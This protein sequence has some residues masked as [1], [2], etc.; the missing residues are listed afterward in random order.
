M[1]E[2]DETRLLAKMARMYYQQ[3]M[4]QAQIAARV[5]M[6]RQKVQR[7]L[8]KSRETG[9]VHILIKPAMG[10]FADMERALEDRYR[11]R[12]VVVTETEAYD[13]QA[14]VMQEVAAAAA[15]YVCRVLRSRDRIVVAWGGNVQRTIDALYH[16]P[17]PNVKGVSVVQGFGGLGDTNDAEHVTFLTQRL[18]GWLGVPGRIM[19]APVLAGSAQA[20]KAFCSDPSIS[21]VLDSARKANLLITGIGVPSSAVRLLKVNRV[22]HPELAGMPSSGVAGDINLRF[23][24]AHGRPVPSDFDERLIGLTLKEMA[25]FDMAVGVA[26]GAL[27][28]KPLLGAVRGRLIN[29]LVTDNVTARRLLDAPDA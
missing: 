5:S 1:V 26:G 13:D 29:V 22:M 9:V 25:A 2:I 8:K 18:A 3:D 27:K 24:D 6:S 11:L 12:D 19:P 20:R 16:H 15:E 17:R 28:F 7:L 21:G 23:F 4:T 14:V 10:A